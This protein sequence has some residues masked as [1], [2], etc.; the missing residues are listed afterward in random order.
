MLC[1]A[2]KWDKIIT[3]ITLYP[4]E[5]LRLRAPLP[6]RVPKSPHHRTLEEE[7]PKP[8][9]RMFVPV[10]ALARAGAS[11]NINI[12]VARAHTRFEANF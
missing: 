6:A 4:L 10:S 11:S 7:L 9:E 2:N 3:F 12:V 1:L 5:M 8:I